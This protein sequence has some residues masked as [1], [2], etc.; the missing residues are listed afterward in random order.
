M[1]SLVITLIGI[2]LV[3]VTAVIALF[4]GGNSFM[5]G[6]DKAT[7]TRAMN[8][9]KEIHLA[10]EAYR[11]ANYGRLMPSEAELNGRTLPEF[12]A[13]EGYYLRHVPPGINNTR[14]Y[15]YENG[16]IVDNSFTIEQCAMANEQAGGS[17]NTED[18][19]S[20]S[21]D[22]DRSNPCCINE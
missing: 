14:S 12:L 15:F 18:I 20:C 8:E 6:G 10:L 9:S 17:G 19:P 21:D 16:F 11:V 4:A 7:Y 22:F 13:E 2:A 3:A 1:S 5:A